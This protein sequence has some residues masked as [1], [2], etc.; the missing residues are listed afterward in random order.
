MG[1]V[2]LLKKPVSFVRKF[3]VGK[4]VGTG[5]GVYQ[6]IDTFDER[7]QEGD[8]ILS[9]AMQAAAEGWIYST[10]WGTAAELVGGAITGGV[11]FYQ[12]EAAQLRQESANSQVPFANAYFNDQPQF[13]TMRQAGLAMA[14]KSEYNLKQAMLGNEA[15]YMHM[16]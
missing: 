2:G 16:E 8:G 13:A 10:G 3:G 14:K 15:R 9:S 4:T 11:E 12:N 7:R 5:M 6:G 1:V